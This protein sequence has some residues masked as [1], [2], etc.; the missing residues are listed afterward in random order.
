[1]ADMIPLLLFLAVCL[2]LMAGY[3]VAFSLAGTALGFAFVG[4]LTGSFDGAF[5][6]A[7]PNRL[8]GIM[9]NVTLIAVPLFIFMGVML[10]RS[11]VA[12]NLLDTMAEVFG[13]LR[14]GLGYS[15]TIVGMLLA[16]STGI[17]GATVVTMGLLSLP[18]MLRHGYDPRIATG[19][20]CASGT[21]GQI[22]P[23]SIV[24][25]LLGDVLSSAYQ[26]AQLDM[27]IYA[28]DTVSVGDL[29]TGALIPGLLL[30]SLYLA[31]LAFVAHTR[32][33][34]M[35]AIRQ[36]Q[37]AATA[38]GLAQR[39]LRG[40][41]PPLLLIIAVLGSILSGI[42]TPTEAAS[43]GAIGAILLA[44][45]RRQCTAAILQE[46]MRSTTRITCMVF[47]ILIG[48]SVFSLVFR[49]F[50]GDEVVA[51]LLNNLPGGKVGA[52][53]AVMLLMF[54]LG[55]VLDFIE[56]TFVVVPIVGPVLLAMGIDPV[57]LGIMIALNLQTS[58]LTPPFGFALFY[59]RGVAPAEVSTRQIYAGVAPFIGLQLLMLLML[60]L[61]PKIATWL[62]DF[63]YT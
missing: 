58:F 47:L 43:V 62:P 38:G 30:V 26:Q 59:L 48:A 9:T 4:Q 40:L 60:A 34:T 37:S 5:L 10:E 25:V 22:I 46:V 51:E 44:A 61:W 42:A 56:I 29:F 52:M 49:G 23:P 53:L 54:L 57:W 16:A 11:R 3:P 55:F 41:L 24:L 39:V 63:I 28:T 27:G 50:G 2:V 14:G 33:E 20:I 36:P 21:L 7:L 35:P 13:Q 12:E 31:W 1:M 17:V 19:V 45:T 8:Y 32:P 15:V 18:T 6:Q